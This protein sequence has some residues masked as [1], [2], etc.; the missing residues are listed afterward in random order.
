MKFTI[1]PADCPQR[2]IPTKLI[3]AHKIDFNALFFTIHKIIALKQETAILEKYGVTM[4]N[5]IT[6]SIPKTYD[7]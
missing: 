4:R 2:R 7:A 1:L 6:G 5:N 3:K